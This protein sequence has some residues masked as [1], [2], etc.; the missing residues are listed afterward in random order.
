MGLPH[1]SQAASA[2]LSP[3]RD[4]EARRS[5]PVREEEQCPAVS[6]ARLTRF[7]QDEDGDDG[8]RTYH[9]DLVA[10]DPDSYEVR[11]RDAQGGWLKAQ[12]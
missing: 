11:A 4:S 7:V 5:V 9:M 3:G 2:A 10:L 12:R 1:M 6:R 8:R